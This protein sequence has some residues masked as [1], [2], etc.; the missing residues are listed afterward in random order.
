MTMEVQDSRYRVTFDP[1]TA[2][3]I[4]R[5][6][7]RLRGMSEYDPITQLLDRVIAAT[8][9]IITLDLVDLY[10]LNSPGIDVLSRFII[11]VRQRGKSQVVI[12]GSPDIPWQSK[13]LKNM[14]RLMPSLQL[15]LK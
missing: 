15:E 9:A 11:N 8:P 3:V 5:G 12:I 10:F 7:I 13:T 1:R 14:Q 2:S 4:F 6:S